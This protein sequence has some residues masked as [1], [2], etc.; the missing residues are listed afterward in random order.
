M[1]ALIWPFFRQLALKIKQAIVWILAHVLNRQ[2]LWRLGRAMYMRARGDV[3][4]QLDSNGERM[5]VRS[6]KR[7]FARRGQSPLAFDVGA[8]VGDWTGAL[9]A[10]ARSLKMAET[11]SVHAF[12]PVP[13]TFQRL[14]ANLAR[15]APAGRLFLVRKAVS[16][17][18]G[19]VEMFVAGAGAGT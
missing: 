1:R 14:Q 8:N 6:F 18:E 12:E 4:N 13:A 17:E 19:P 9:F 10:E 5:L 11:L 7:E 2:S 16:S 15:G 3:A